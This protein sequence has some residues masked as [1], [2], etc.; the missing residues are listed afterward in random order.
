MI[1]Q[2]F[3]SLYTIKFIDIKF[4]QIILRFYKKIQKSFTLVKVCYMIFK[5][6]VK[7]MKISS[8]LLLSLIFKLM[9]T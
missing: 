2:Q 9:P 8:N 7:K 4:I 3:K 1:S 6:F 5:K